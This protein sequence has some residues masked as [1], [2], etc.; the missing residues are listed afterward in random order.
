M[1]TERTS[2][3]EANKNKDRLSQ[4]WDKDDKSTEFGNTNDPNYDP[5]RTE[6]GIDIGKPSNPNVPTPRNMDQ[7]DNP[8]HT[9][10]APDD[11]LKASGKMSGGLPNE[12]IVSRYPSSGSTYKGETSIIDD[13]LE[14]LLDEDKSGPY[15][16]LHDLDAG[17]GFFIAVEPN[18]T[19]DQTIVE[20]QKQ[21]FNLN[22]HYSTPVINENGETILD[23]VVIEEFKRNEDK[24]IDLDYKGNPKKGANFYH[25]PRV[26]QLRQYAVKAVMKDD[27]KIPGD[28]ALIVRVF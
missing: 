28:G 12:P 11:R 6:N 25:L 7:P 10:V 18:K 24:T 22:K 5:S 13:A 2:Q 8:P 9:L 4:S 17:G 20:A 15:P 21:V 1:P 23:M 26:V 14:Y 19:I 16:E 3:S 27:K